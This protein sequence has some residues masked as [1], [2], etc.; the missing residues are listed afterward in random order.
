M[1]LGFG[2]FVDQ[3]EGQAMSTLFPAIR[4]ALGLTY[5]N[6]DHRRRR[7]GGAFRP[8]RL[9]GRLAGRSLRHKHRPPSLCP[10]VLGAPVAFVTALLPNLPQ[11]FGTPP[12][13]YG[14]PQG[15]TGGN[16]P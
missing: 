9:P 8:E 1:A 7:G 11:R 6:L 14:R 16:R 10:R 2:H 3:G 15:G 4:D 13:F 5:G 12:G